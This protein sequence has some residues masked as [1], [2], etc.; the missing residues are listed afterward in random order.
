MKG[1]IASGSQIYYLL[2]FS[3]YNGVESGVPQ[4]SIL[5]TVLFNLFIN[6]LE[7][8]LR[9]KK[10]AYDTKL[11]GIV[12]TKIDCEELWKDLSKLSEWAAFLMK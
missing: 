11:F 12:K 6:E 1:A 10:F 9:S 2:Q 7:L 4:G 5:Q 3:Q 8:G